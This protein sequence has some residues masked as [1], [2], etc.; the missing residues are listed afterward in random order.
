MTSSAD[1]VLPA[2]N[3]LPPIPPS[4]ARSFASTAVPAASLNIPAPPPP[5]LPGYFL[6]S[7]DVKVSITAY[8]T[9]SEAAKAY[10]KSLTQVASAAS[11]FGAALESCARCKGAG[12]TA[13]GLMGGSG[14]QYLVASNM[15]LLSDAIYRGFE[16]PLLHEVDNYKEKNTENEERY[17]KQASEKTRELHKRETQHLKLARQKKRN[18]SSFRGALLDLTAKIDE[19]E[20]LKYAHFRTAL[21]LSQVTSARILDSTALVVRA[22]VEVFEKIASKGWDASG[23]LDDLISRAGDP[24]AANYSYGNSGDGEIFSILPTESILPSPHGALSRAGSISGVGGSIATEGKYQSL[25]GALSQNGDYDECDDDEDTHS[26]FS[27][28]FSSPGPMKVR[29]TR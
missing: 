17:K 22:E 25:T 4:P 8:E 7:G 16:V 24:F 5:P 11:S 14:L 12:D 6:S 13:D 9:L 23:G 18:L 3:Q 10:R 15:H 20:N 2:H 21:D 29:C 19:L 28:G 27:G 1:S 26:I